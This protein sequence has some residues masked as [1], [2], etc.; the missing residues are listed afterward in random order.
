MKAK[1]KIELSTCIEIELSTYIEIELF[2]YTEKKKKFKGEKNFELSTYTY[3]KEEDE[4]Y[5]TF[6]STYIWGLGF[7]VVSYIC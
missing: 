3:I 7:M 5:K 1:I 4:A 6:I 2:T